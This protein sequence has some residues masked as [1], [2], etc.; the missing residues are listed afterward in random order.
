MEHLLEIK[1]IETCFKTDG[2]MVKAVDG[3]SLYLDP[4]EIIGI[5]G[6][7]GSGKSV[8]MMSMLQLISSPGKITGGEVYIQG[9]EQNMLEL[10]VDSEKMRH[11]RG[12]KVSMIFQEP[13]TSLNPVLTIGYQIQE[14]IIEH[15]K[16]SKEDA[17]K[18]TIE[19]LK[20]VNIPD[21]EQRFDYYPQQFSG[22]M[23][24]RIMIAM[25]MSSEPTV[26]V[27][28]EATTALDVT[29]Q[30]QLLEMI[31]DIAK[32]TN[33]AVIIVTHNLGIVARFA[34]RI[35]VMY[36][37]SVV[38]MTD[39]KRL[40]ANPEHPY[41]R[42]LLRAIPRLD[43]PKDRILIPIEGLPPNP[44]TRPSYCPFYERCEYRMDRC[45]ECAKPGLKELEKKHFAACHLTEEEKA[46]KAKEIADK[47]VKKAPKILVGDELCL[48]VKNVRKYF[49]IYSGMMRKK[50][51]EVK[52]IED[53]NF[54]AKKG[55]TLGI[56]GESGCG[57]T[58]LARC[59]MR[60]YKP[61]EGE[62]IFNGTD[63]AGFN[64]R[65]M[66]PFRRKISMIF[67][68]PFSSL[69]PRQTAESIVGESL[70]LHKL[71]KNKA[72]YNAR[73][74][75]LFRIV[76]LDPAL[77]YR[78]PHEF[79]GGQRQRIGIARALSSEPDM[80]ICDE[81][82]SALDVSIQ[83]QI[84]NLLEELQS[85]LGLTYLFI[86]HDLAVVKHISNRI[87][88]MYL[89]RV[90]EIADC[91][92]LY[93]NT[94]HPYTKTLLS[95]VP[96]ADPAVEESRERV[97]I[98]GEVPSLTKRPEGCPFHDRCSHVCDRCRREVPV[99]KDVGKGHEVACFLYEQQFNK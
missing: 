88:V 67:Q 40:F 68:D 41:T 66:Y 78:V 31:R 94:L 13:M 39:A 29:T 77:K 8:T 70:L 16:M 38:E 10:G 84:I 12:G 19:M 97:P 62:I 82:I 83:A 28:D 25:A 6:E 92:E 80:I 89:G 23:R 11:M 3:V 52:A 17:K 53:I 9:E 26:L 75:E 63:I 46:A 64:D 22:G 93:S 61:E 76:G 14:N 33:T 18:R 72:E 81:P 95:A 90:V 5:V 50:T 2:Q 87:L 7:S 49:P 43:D 32:K 73:V 15:L 24:Q 60:V 47:E 56:V 54:Y 36:S 30:A 21:A 48:N 34:E 44:A 27:A 20:L 74:D 37:G 91:D 55:E 59:I 85:Q 98:R 1:N 4:G 86:A 57:K 42:A 51:G 35:Y 69:D 71:V 99:L 65:Q 79:S 96:V 45:R 58:T